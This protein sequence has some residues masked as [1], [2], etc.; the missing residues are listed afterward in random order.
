M[1]RTWVL[2]RQK[3]EV[4][5]EEKNVFGEKSEFYQGDDPPAEVH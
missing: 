3:D 2:L 1:L 5:I 4:M